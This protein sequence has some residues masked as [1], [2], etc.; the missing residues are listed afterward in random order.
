VPGIGGK[1]L[2]KPQFQRKGGVVKVIGIIGV[3]GMYRRD[4]EFSA[5]LPGGQ[6]QAEFRMGVDNIQVKGSCQVNHLFF[7]KDPD[8]VLGFV[9]KLEGFYPENPLLRR[10][11]G[12]LNR[13]NIDPVPPFNQ[14][15][16]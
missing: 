1:I 5:Y 10:L 3:E 12:V 2:L 6:E 8:P 9:G 4:V 15:V 16:L 13:E 7:D 11:V 14:P